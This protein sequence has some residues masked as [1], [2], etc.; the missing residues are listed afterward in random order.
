MTL[1][2]IGL[3]RNFT[4]YIQEFVI[5]YTGILDSLMFKQE[6]YIVYTRICDGLYRNFTWSMQEFHRV[7]TG[8][9]YG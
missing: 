2:N 9:L 8:I 1:D 3:Y 7:N 6:F 4:R 5:V